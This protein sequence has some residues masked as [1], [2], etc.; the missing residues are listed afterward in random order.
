MYRMSPKK[1]Y[2]L[3]HVG[4]WIITIWLL[5]TSC[6]Q[7]NK[8]NPS[9]HMQ[10][11]AGRDHTPIYRIRTPD[12]WI[13]R[14]PLPNESLLDTTKAIS[15]F[16]IRESGETIRITIHNFPSQTIEERIA[17]QQQVARWKKQFET[18]F[19]SSSSTIQQA[20]SGYNGL[21][22]E[23]TGIM[24][25]QQIMVLGWALQLPLEHYQTILHSSLQEKD[26][27]RSDVTIKAVG[28]LSLMQKHKEAIIAAA[29]SFELIEEIPNRS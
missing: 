29:R 5:F 2:Q 20:F 21:L 13:K 6:Q 27:M 11:I 25:G 8:N 14:D 12:S 10:E 1:S 24:N 17:P 19:T 9:V 26:S 4:S 3:F 18:L 15:E 7:D 28:P 23:G 16:I 22:F